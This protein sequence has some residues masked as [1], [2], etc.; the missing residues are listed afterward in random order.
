MKDYLADFL[1]HPMPTNG[2]NPLGGYGSK[3]SKAHSNFETPYVVGYQKAQKSPFDTFEP[4]TDREFEKSVL[5]G[6]DAPP[7]TPVVLPCVVCGGGGGRR[8][9]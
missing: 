5:A 6:S 3:G 1:A 8:V 7:P 9:D 2:E 4:P